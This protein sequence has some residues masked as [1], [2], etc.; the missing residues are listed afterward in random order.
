M[1]LAYGW[2][3]IGTNCCEQGARTVNAAARG[4]ACALLAAI[5]SGAAFAQDEGESPERY[6]LMVREAYYEVRQA[7]SDEGG[8]CLYREQAKLLCPGTGFIA[9]EKHYRTKDYDLLVISMGETGSGTRWWDWKII[10]EDGQ[11]ARIK[12][13][14]DE[15]LECDIWIERLNFLSNEV[16]FA[17]RQKQHRIMA[18][19]HAGE[20]TMQKVNLNPREP[21]DEDTCNALF[22]NYEDCRNFDTSDPKNCKMSLSNASHF[23]LLR[24]EDRYAGF[25]YGDMGRLCKAACST[26]KPMDQKTFFKKVCRR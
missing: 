24:T 17:Y 20:L 5:S 15:C 16:V 18:R 11:Q 23:G 10:V 12:S 6:N 14:A 1:N 9:F 7:P 21:L 3:Q 25:S 26:G 4:V 8:K 22:G 2:R 13:L 19:F